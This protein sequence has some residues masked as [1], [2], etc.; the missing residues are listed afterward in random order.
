MDTTV[1]KLAT[2]EPPAG[3]R[4]LAGAFA[5]LEATEPGSLVRCLLP[6][7]LTCPPADALR[8]RLPNVR[9]V[10][11]E[12]HPLVHVD[13]VC[14]PRLTQSWLDASQGA[15][16]VG[17][18][19][20]R[21]IREFQDEQGSFAATGWY[22][23]LMVDLTGVAG[24][25]SVVVVLAPSNELR[26]VE[27]QLPPEWL[28]ATSTI[29]MRLATDG[30]IENITDNVGELLGRAANSL[31]GRPALELVHSEDVALVSTAW[32]QLLRSPPPHD[33]LR[34]R[35]LAPDEASARWFEATS[36]NA[37][38]DPD[39]A[40]VITELRDIDA[41]VRAEQASAESLRT[42]QRL[43][44]VLDEV[45]N[46]VI[47][48]RLGEG[49]V[50]ANR[51][52]HDQL[53]RLEVGRPVRE[54]M[55]EQPLSLLADQIIEHLQAG[56]RWTGD[57]EHT[58]V[59]GLSRTLST[60]VCPVADAEDDADD[61]GYFG[62]V[63]HDVTAERAHARAL[64]DQART[65][66]LTT[67]PNRLALMEC[68][69]ALRNA[70]GVARADDQ[71]A[72]C[73]ID[74]DNLK[75]VNDG[76]GHGAGDQLLV[77]LAEELR[78]HVGEDLVARF[79]GDEF[80]VV[81]EHASLD[82]VV[83]KAHELSEVISRV[84]VPGV[85]SHLTASI[86]VAVSPRPDVRPEAMLRDADAAM[87]QAKRRG[88][89]QVL[90]F[91]EAMH[92]QATRRFV[93]ETSLRQA[94]DD[95]GLEAHLQ[96]FV[97]LRTDRVRGFEA[98]ARWGLVQPLEFVATAEESGLIVPLG[99]WVLEQALESMAQ[100]RASDPERSDLSIAV[101]VSG[102]QL[103]DRAFA[104]RTLGIIT[105][106]GTDPRDVILE[107]TESVLIDHHDDIERS[108]RRLRDAGLRLAL[109]DFGSGYS[110]IAYLRR[111]PIEILKLDTTYTQALLTDPETRI[112]AEA[113]VTMAERLGM[114]VVAEGVETHEQLACVREMG[115]P[116]AQGYLFSPAQP[117]ES[118]LLQGLDSF[119]QG[120]R[121]LRATP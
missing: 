101:N 11:S 114:E 49:V 29:R 74:V 23:L 18:T 84:Q 68:L 34:C 55:T 54:L 47:L 61:S 102:R 2:P 26:D 42:S 32:T 59:D 121:D 38:D 94:I 12:D 1:S 3:G 108:L 31:L 88:R 107:L 14:H 6:S 105:D 119:E 115:I 9:W 35:F 60:T 120:L 83:A 91:D 97:D 45:D 110:S 41:E 89:D 96:P 50:Y 16:R 64:S 98:L 57:V 62:I 58:T 106:Q 7:G 85:S 76:L 111:Y 25:N 77:A 10:V 113:I 79:G 56:Q 72:L 103:V 67:L 39:S 4:D 65:D 28:H 15:S 75:V 99:Q 90:L 8:D 78:C 69:E 33:P 86:G 40:V 63:M 22:D 5:L 118:I 112:I 104:D 17:R 70:G 46:M 13:P 81:L 95:G 80:V 87:Y 82:E 116:I 109:D 48:S 117:V 21:T 30:S 43:R 93:V 66:P 24:I 73:F 19:R 27:R 51:A 71:I 44:R 20:L 52:A 92:Q 37:L 53:A 36:W 100:V